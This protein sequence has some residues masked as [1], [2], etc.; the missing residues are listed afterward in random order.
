MV[1]GTKFVYSMLSWLILGSYLIS[2]LWG[3]TYMELRMKTLHYLGCKIVI[4]SP[5]FICEAINIRMWATIWLAFLYRFEKC[6]S[7]FCKMVSHIIGIGQ[8]DWLFSVVSYKDFEGLRNC[9]L[10]DFMNNFQHFCIQSVPTPLSK[11]PWS[12]FKR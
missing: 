2:C 8:L 5:L 6:A 12:V 3:K 4:A 7:E 10:L 9:F 1:V 11:F